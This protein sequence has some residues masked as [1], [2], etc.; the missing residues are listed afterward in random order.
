MH[1]LRGLTAV[2]WAAFDPDW[3]L[4]SYPT[5]RSAIE[6]ESPEAILYFYLQQGRR[7]GHSPNMFFDEAWYLRTYSDATAAIRR[8]DAASGFDHYCRVGF[9]DHSPHWLFDEANYRRNYPQL[10]DGALQAADFVNGYDHYLR[11]GARENRVAHWLF[12][13]NVYRAHLEFEAAKEAEAVG[14]FRHY[15]DQI[16]AGEPEPRTTLYFDPG[17]YLQHY[18]E[19]AG[20]V[21]A[22]RWQSALHHYLTNDTPTVFDPLPEFS[23]SYYLDRDGDAAAA[24]AAGAQRNGYQHF[25]ERGRLVTQSP[26]AELDLAYYV[27]LPTVRADLRRPRAGRFYALPGDRQGAGAA[28]GAAA[29]GAGQ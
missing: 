29:R 2:A 1:A 4:A 24:V 14:P 5:V 12:D 25:L 20:A 6:D 11:H 19:V 3:Y 22:N 27:R 10:S 26:S 9:A 18:Q 17:W 23:E 16:A 13:P 28:A 8:G 7:L 15:L 21:S